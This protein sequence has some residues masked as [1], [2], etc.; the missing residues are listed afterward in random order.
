MRRWTWWL[1]WGTAAV[2]FAL[3]GVSIAIIQIVGYSAATQQHNWVTRGALIVAFGGF[4]VVGALVA[5]RQPGNAVGWIFS[6]VAL[7]VGVNVAS[8]EYANYVF[9]EHPASLPG[10]YLAAWLSLWT[11]FPVIALIVILPLVF[12]DGRPPGPGWRIVLRAIAA[13]AAVLTVL[14]ALRPGPMSDPG[15]GP[16]PDNPVGI[17]ALHSL[18]GAV[19]ELGSVLLVVFLACSGASA[20]VRFRRS[21]GDERQQLKWLTYGIGIWTVWVPLS[22]VNAGDVRDIAFALAIAVLPASAAIAMF[23]YHLYDVDRVISRT[24][25]YGALTVIL[26]AAYTG[27][28]LAGQAVFSSFAGGSK[29]A[30]AG[31]TLVVAALFL[32]LRARLQ[33]VV[34][35]RF[36]RRRYDAQGT[37][38]DFAVRL[39]QQVDVTVLGSEL[40]QVVAD[41][42]QPSHTTL[43]LRTEETR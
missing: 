3:Y 11:W 17:G 42:M 14:W 36:N 4:A 28:V 9:V 10:G 38:D 21:R 40:V 25:V 33:T 1:A 30:I 29:L 27:L 12:P 43:W 22:L 35:R 34:D 31:S 37:L 7:L 20:V 32:P 26:G 13:T 41:T 5:S 16:Y 23:K 39:R 6:A 19:D 18:F 8:G 2:T 15:K 24:L